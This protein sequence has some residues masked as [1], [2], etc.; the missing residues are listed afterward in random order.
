MK[1]GGGKSK[2][3]SY[4][5]HVAELLTKAY[6]PDNDGEFRRIYSYPIPSKGARPGDLKAM[7]KYHIA[8]NDEQMVL[9]VSWPFSVECKNYKD[10]KLPF[11]GLWAKESAVWD[12]MRQAEETASQ[13]PHISGD[14]PYLPLVV[15]RLFRTA[16]VAM[17]NG[18]TFGRLHALFGIY[19]KLYYTLWRQSLPSSHALHLFLLSDFLKW[20]DWGVYKVSSSHKYIRSLIKKGE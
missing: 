20:I 3:S 16:D 10:I 4:E 14:D 5:R 2:G 18:S 9:D 7:R 11:C 17:I 1:P 8:A 12:W 15:F 13:L 19:S 6:Y